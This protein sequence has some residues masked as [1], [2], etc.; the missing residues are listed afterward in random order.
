MKKYFFYHIYVC[1]YLVSQCTKINEKI[2]Y[3]SKI[4]ISHRYNT[5]LCQARNPH[6]SQEHVSNVH[7]L[8][9]QNVKIV[10][11]VNTPMDLYPKIVNGRCVSN[12]QEISTVRYYLEV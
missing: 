5:Q 9:D 3:C 2:D 6:L 11:H 4:P 12:H 7:V 10:L 1:T 8:H